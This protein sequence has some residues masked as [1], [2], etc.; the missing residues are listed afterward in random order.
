MINSFEKLFTNFRLNNAK[1]YYR[2]D[3]GEH[4]IAEVEVITGAFFLCKKEVYEKTGGLDET[5]FMYGEDID[6]CYAM[7]QRGYKNYYYGKASVLHHKGESTVKDKTYLKMFYGAMQI[8]VDKYYKRR[9][10][11][12]IVL[13]SGLK[14]KYL[15]EKLKCQAD[16]RTKSNI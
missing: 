6:I 1:S 7:L 12:Y 9:I 4:D 14:L 3:V 8:F 11:K 15:I 16:N 2:K 5:Y 13:S 10:F